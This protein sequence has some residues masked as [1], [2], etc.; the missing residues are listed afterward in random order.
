MH[1]TLIN[2]N[3]LWASRSTQTYICDKGGRGYFLNFW[4]VDLS[5]AFWDINNNKISLKNYNECC[6][7]SKTDDAQTCTPGAS[8]TIKK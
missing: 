4:S 2:G 5:L 3:T 7:L 6:E 8:N 1:K